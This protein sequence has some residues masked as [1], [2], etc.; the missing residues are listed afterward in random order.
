MRLMLAKDWLD[1]SCYC[2]QCPRMWMNKTAPGHARLVQYG[3]A[4]M[5]VEHVKAM[6]GLPS[7]IRPDSAVPCLPRGSEVIVSLLPTCF[8]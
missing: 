5:A 2:L 4:M 6:L 7:C 1:F 3:D 8:R